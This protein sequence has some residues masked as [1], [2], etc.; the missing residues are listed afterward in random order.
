MPPCF[1]EMLGQRLEKTPFFLFSPKKIKYII[2]FLESSRWNVYNSQWQVYV[3]I[4]F[5][6]KSLAITRGHIYY[7][8][9]LFSWQWGPFLWIVPICSSSKKPPWLQSTKGK[10]KLFV[11]GQAAQIELLHGFTRVGDLSSCFVGQW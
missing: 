8:H 10:Q 3:R 2:I 7:S 9:W 4:I 6:M 1:R 5:S 11:D